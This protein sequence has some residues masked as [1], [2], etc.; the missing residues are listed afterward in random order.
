MEIRGIKY[1]AP[2]FDYSGYG[3][4]SRGYVLAL[5][6]LGVPITIDPMFFGESFDNDSEDYRI[7][8]SLCYK[9][10]DYNIVIVQSTPDLWEKHYEPGR[11]NIGY[12]VWETD[13]L[14]PKWPGCI[15]V[16]D[17]VMCSSE[18]NVDVFKIS[19]VTKPLFSIPHGIDMDRFKNIKPYNVVG[20]D[21]AAYKFYN[22]A[23]FIERK[24]PVSLI[25]SYWHAF[26]NKEN[27]A[28]IFKT[29]K[30]GFSD[31][32]KDVIRN[33]IKRL[34]EVCDADYYPPIYLVLDELSRDQILGLHK[35]GD[36]YVSLDRGEGF[37]LC[38]GGNTN[39][40]LKDN[41]KLAKDVVKGDLVLSGD[42]KFH[43]VTEV[44]SRH[45][46]DGI[47]ISSNLHEDLLVSKDHP[48]YAIKNLSRWKR[49]N[50]STEKIENNLSWILADD[51]NIGDYVAVPKPILNT[52]VLNTYLRIDDFVFLDD[53]LLESKKPNSIFRDIKI[54]EDVLNMFGW[55]IAVGSIN[56]DS[57]LE[58]DCHINEYS[59]LER[60]ACIFKEVF[61]VADASIFLQKYNNKSK[62]IISNKMLAVLFTTLFGSG[63]SNKKIP[64]FL[65]NSGSD[66][67]Q[68]LVGLFSGDGHNSGYSYSLSTTSRVLAYQ[69]KAIFNSMGC[70]SRISN[71]GTRSG[72][73]FD[74]YIVSVANSDYEYLTGKRIASYREFFIETKNFFIVKVTNK[75]NVVYNDLMYDFSIDGSKNFVGNGILLHNCPFEAGAFSKPIIV[76]GWGGATEYAKDDT[77]F[78]VDYS[79]TP[80]SGM[81]W[82]PWYRVDQLW[83]EPSCLSAI[84]HM[85]YVYNNQEAAKKVGEN[86]Y[87]FISNNLTWDNVGKKM[88]DVI[89]SL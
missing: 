65:F 15:N 57:S 41:V 6:R 68:L 45:V 69:V 24:N 70:C 49:Y 7:L 31:S 29:Y 83:A 17:A 23:Q 26:Q 52:G 87:K 79:L 3:Q 16:M 55:Y 73:N 56:N 14:H 54:T 38:V 36:C 27:V 48:I 21:D 10:I 78:K 58:F 5:H 64:E 4:A 89:R 32:E 30:I 8:Q 39:I 76:T 37:G 2:L 18:F 77:S 71:V 33:T 12:T 59:I 63:A 72:G 46:K 86:L 1:V 53:M 75:I 13:K 40:L 34:K 19:G 35:Y 22:I 50:W 80:V 61:N 44:T 67:K 84:N 51:I 81:P 82:S 85:R 43:S 62:L 25:K 66:L 74:S 11:F 60:I 9:K 88:L 42:G 47:K 20:V 28:L